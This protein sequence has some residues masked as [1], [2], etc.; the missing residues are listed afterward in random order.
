MKT[1]SWVFTVL[2]VASLMTACS[3]S[4]VPEPVDEESPAIAV[5]AWTDRTE[6]FMEYPPLVAGETG[7]FA[8]HLTDLT[9]LQ[10]VTDGRVTVRLEG[11]A[12][13]TFRTDGPSSPG[14]FGVDVMPPAARRY[15]LVVTLDGEVLSDVHRL[16][17]V[18]V[19]ADPDA[20]LAAVPPEED[21][22][23]TFLKEQ[24]WTLDFATAAVETKSLRAGLTVPAEIQPR[25][26]GEVEVRATTAGRVAAGAGRPVGTRVTRGETLVELISRNERVGER[27]VLELEL[28]E[29]EAWF[30][31][32]RTDRARVGR[33][34]S[35]GAVPTRRLTEAQIAEE[36]AEIR[37]RI[38]EEELRHLDLSRTGEG[39]GT[40]DERVL[41]RAP[42]SGVVADAQVTPGATV[43]AGQLLFR[44]VAVDRVY[45]VGA[46]PEA[47]IGQLDGLEDAQLEAPGL[48]SPVPIDRLV[49]V[50]RVVDHDTRTVPVTFEL[51]KPPPSIAIGQAVSLRLFTSTQRSEPAVPA[52][53]VVDD[54]GQPVVFVQIGGERFDR[55]LVRLG[56]REG[57]LVQ[58]LE[59]VR[60]GERIVTRGANLVR[61]AALSPQVPA[62]GHVH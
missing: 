46:V 61:L 56:A 22:G 17:A 60:A 5:T 21:A 13:D 54:G 34:V 47:D 36:T 19:Y 39:T 58:I 43:E 40:P 42:I 49:A 30:R 4:V 50:G 52:S 31:L 18:S 28:A 14:I 3:V 38:V 9:T 27:P 33:L 32:A 12:I 11:Q 59:G 26:G 23:I 2:A 16:G 55:R 53:A 6:L 1:T 48:E 62:H 10:P 51:V 45:V 44:L 41:A 37:V 15:Q 20:A 24:Q 35:A 57:G 29:A 7:R 8:V 25:V